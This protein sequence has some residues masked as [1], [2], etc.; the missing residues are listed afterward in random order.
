[1]KN[2]I[3]THKNCKNCGACCGI[4]P[5]RESEYKE[6]KKYLKKFPFI[7]KLA[8][9]RQ[10]TDAIVCPFRNNEKSRCDIYRVRPMACR[11]MG[12]VGAMQCKH[13]NSAGL[14][15]R[16]YLKGH[17]REPTVILNAVDWGGNI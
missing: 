6:V 7:R 15:G 16:G 13:G 11:L 4:I 10:E 2:S 9:E 17:G 1:M 12:V 5:V 8:S 14:D 3:P